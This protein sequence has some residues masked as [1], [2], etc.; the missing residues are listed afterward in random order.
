[1]FS[2]KTLIILKTENIDEKGER[3]FAHTEGRDDETTR[4]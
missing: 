4:R 1:M 2:G 3:P